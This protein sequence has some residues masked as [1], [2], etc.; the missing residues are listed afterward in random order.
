[1]GHRK[2][3]NMRMVMGM[4]GCQTWQ[5]EAQLGP[6]NAKG[7]GMEDCQTEQ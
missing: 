2:C 3:A 1:M 4:E 7:I 6:G 5:C